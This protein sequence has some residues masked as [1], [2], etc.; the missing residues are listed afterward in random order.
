VCWFVG[1]RKQLLKSIELCSMEKARTLLVLYGSQTGCAQEVAERIAWEGKRRLFRVRL[2]GIARHVVAARRA[3][4]NTLKNPMNVLYMTVS[5]Y[6]MCTET[7]IW[8]ARPFNMG[9]FSSIPI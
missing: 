4:F 8:C 6:S 2:S 3:T 7:Q 5:E 9:E 1:E